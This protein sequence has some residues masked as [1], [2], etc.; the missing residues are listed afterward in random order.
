MVMN[1]LG[2]LLLLFFISAL[3]VILAI[4]WFRLSGF[5]M[6]LLRCLCA[7]LAGAAAL[8]PALFLQRLFVIAGA[9]DYGGRW[10][11]LLQ[12]FVR[13]ALTEEFSR[14][15]T[16]FF[17]FLAAGDFKKTDPLR[18]EEGRSGGFS[19]SRGIGAAAWGAAAGLLAGLGFSIIENAA[20]GAADFRV[21]L[22]RIFTAAP[23]H[24]A[25][26]AR[27]GSALLM[28]KEQPR[29]AVFRFFSAALIHGIYNILITRPGISVLL[30]VLIALF[31]LASAALEIRGGRRQ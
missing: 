28:F 12:V 4:F 22:P 5:P 29:Y 30:G 9:G 26:G 11:P 20:Y 19:G 17:F 31:A 1:G 14:L 15:V 23:L 13:I 21:T 3:P 10:G 6:S 25:C 7:L 16:L 24:G 18:F 2:I 27:V 8:F